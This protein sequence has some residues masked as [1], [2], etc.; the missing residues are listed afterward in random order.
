MRRAKI[1]YA[2]WGWREAWAVVAANLG[3][4]TNAVTELT[5]RLSAMGYGPSLLPVN[6]AR[7]GLELVLRAM[8]ARKPSR[9][10][11]LIP[12]Y[13]CA[14]VPN[15]VRDAGLEPVALAVGP[16][17]NLDRHR[18]TDRLGPDTLALIAVHMYGAPL[19]MGALSESCA[20]AG[21]YLIDDAAHVVGD[22]LGTQGDAGL[23]S[24][25]QSKTLTG[26]APAG[27]GMLI[28]QDPDIAAAAARLATDLLQPA[29]MRLRQ[30]MWFSFAYLLDPFTLPLTAHFPQLAQRLAAWCAVRDKTAR[31]MNPAAASA[32]LVQLSRLTRI[33]SGRIALLDAYHAACMADARLNMVQYQPGAYRTRMITGWKGGCDAAQM[34]AGLNAAGIAARSLYPPWS[35]EAAR[36][37]PAGLDRMIELPGH[38]ALTS[39]DAGKIIDTAAHL[40]KQKP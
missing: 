32:V 29:N 36:L 33:R 4:R 37:L 7:T 10:R 27:G 38:L 11:V 15:A 12:A 1:G 22:R 19:D 8:H 31:I 2:N 24:F 26:G 35:N 5:Q 9:N 20:S 39:A 30:H 40:L 14:A 6:R 3:L 28:I 18:L 21:T 17:L 23:L 25:N 13:C 16:D 34:K